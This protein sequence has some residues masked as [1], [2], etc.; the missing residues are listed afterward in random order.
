MWWIVVFKPTRNLTTSY[1][2]SC[3]GSSHVGCR[4]GHVADFGQQEIRKS[5][6]NRAL[7][8]WHSGKE[9]ACQC[10]RHGL[11]PWVG[12]IPWRKKWQ[13]TPVFLPGESHRQR[14]LV[15]YSPCG[16]QELDKTEEAL[17]IHGFHIHR[18]TD[19]E[20]DCPTPF[21]T[22]DSRIRG[23]WYPQGRVTAVLELG[24]CGFW[25]TSLC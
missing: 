20:P 13:P 24:P 23:F 3:V 4:L 7:P 12:K 16:C 18:S 8:R 5:N 6:I 11:G 10:R 2:N 14:S 9:S 19:P 15:G 25:G 1:T 17:P 21:Y 22:R